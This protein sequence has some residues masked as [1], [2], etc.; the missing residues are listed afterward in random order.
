VQ[1][2]QLEE[3]DDVNFELPEESMLLNPKTEK[4]FFK[5]EESQFI[6]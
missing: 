1:L 6:H 3:L 4:S 5:E 2:P